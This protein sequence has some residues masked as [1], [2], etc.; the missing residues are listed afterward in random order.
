MQLVDLVAQY[1]ELKPEIDEAIHRVLDSGYF[2]M[3]PELK[4]LEEEV[5]EYLKVKHAI[6]CGSGTD[7]LQI[8]LMAHEIGSGDE[9]I[10]TPFT[11]VATVEVIALLGAEPVYVDIDP[12]TYNI[13]PDA[14][15]DAITARTKAIIPVHLYGQSAEMEKITPIAE[16][17]GLAVIEDTAQAIGA[18]RNGDFAGTFGDVGCI[19]F[20]PSKNL[21]A[22]GDAGMMVTDDDELNAKLRMIAKHGS[23]VKYQHEALGV[24][25]R[26]DALQAAIL[27]VKLP[28]IDDWNRKRFEVASNYI[29]NISA[30]DVTFPT[31]ADGNT[32]IFHQFSIQVP[33]RGDFQAYL[34]ERDIPTAVHYPI[35]LHKQ[36]AFQTVGRN[37]GVP[38]AEKVSDH[39]VSLPI[40][41][42][43]PQDDQALVIET[44]NNYFS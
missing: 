22:F 32:H 23:R 7:A 20:F 38:V 8:A 5:E 3:G 6:G 11:F 39:I 19:S 14:I 41:P 21:G 26:L 31:I 33:D 9:V 40:Y 43:M 37:T 44:V 36:P 15:R 35:P 1:N 2:I 12:D 42:E 4:S 34:K 28:H 13:D 27:R 16:E 18:R 25:S 30:D 10:T 29:E 17:Y 24:N